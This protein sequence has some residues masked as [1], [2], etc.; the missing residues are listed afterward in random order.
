MEHSAIFIRQL[1]EFLKA[2]KGEYEGVLA[3]VAGSPCQDNS[4]SGICL[5]YLGFSGSRSVHVHI[6]NI[7]TWIVTNLYPEVRMALVIE[8][9]G[10]ILPKQVAYLLHTLG[11]REDDATRKRYFFTNLGFNRKALTRCPPPWD[12]GWCP[13]PALTNGVMP[14]WMRTQGL[15]L[16]TNECMWNTAYY[17]LKDFLHKKEDI[18]EGEWSEMEQ[19]AK[20]GNN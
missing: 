18:P 17:T 19:D 2:K 9:A 13:R 15:S 10:S 20:R 12:E 5:G 14:P 11:L 4:G 6:I 7:I 16:I 3:L 1:M 8:N